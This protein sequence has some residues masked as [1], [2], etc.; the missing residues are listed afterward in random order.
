MNPEEQVDNSQQHGPRNKDQKRDVHDHAHRLTSFCQVSPFHEPLCCCI[1]I[2]MNDIHRVRRCDRVSSKSGALISIRAPMPS[3][4]PARHIAQRGPGG[5]HPGSPASLR[6]ACVPP[7]IETRLGVSAPL[8][9]RNII[10]EMRRSRSQDDSCYKRRRGLR[11][12]CT[13]INEMSTQLVFRPQL[14]PGNAAPC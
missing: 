8:K 2:C 1:L 3:R 10:R 9:R 5:R 4:L 6:A 7:V 14:C 11:I 13:W 12:S